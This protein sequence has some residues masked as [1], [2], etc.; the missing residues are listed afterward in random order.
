MYDAAFAWAL[1]A[2]KTMREGIEPTADNMK[3]FNRRVVRHL[4]NLDF[5]GMLIVEPR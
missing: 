3:R 1:A 2:N 4:N 5:E